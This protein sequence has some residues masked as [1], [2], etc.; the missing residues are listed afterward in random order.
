[1]DSLGP[2]TGI[3]TLHRPASTPHHRVVALLLRLA[4]GFD[5]RL[6]RE[7]QQIRRIADVIGR[8]LHREDADLD[9]GGGIRQRGVLAP[10]AL[11]GGIFADDISNAN[12]AGQRGVGHYHILPNF[13]TEHCA[14]KTGAYFPNASAP[15]FATGSSS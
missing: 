14:P 15:A 7:S 2:T 6:H 12:L 3:S 13:Q 10:L 9:F 5:E 8:R 11:V 1:M 4:E